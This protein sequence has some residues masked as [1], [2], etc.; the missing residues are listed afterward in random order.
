MT[1]TRHRLPS[2]AYEPTFE[3]KIAQAR[4]LKDKTYC[5]C[6]V[7]VT[8]DPKKF[9]AC[10]YCHQLGYTCCDERIKNAKTT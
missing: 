7:L 2:K 1:N 9:K 3:E 8:Y 5:E 4:V 10:Y 6:H